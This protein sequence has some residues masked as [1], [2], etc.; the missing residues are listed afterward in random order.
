MTSDLKLLMGLDEAGRGPVL[1][2]MVIAGVVFAESSNDFFKDYGIKDSK[3][4]SLKAREEMFR[5]ID[6]EA[7]W[8]K[9]AV[10]WPEVIDRFVAL[11]GLNHL[12]CD[13]MADIISSLE[14]EKYVYVD[15][16]LSPD[17]FNG[18]LTTRLNK[19]NDI[20]CSFK[21]DTIYPVVSAASILAKVTRD[22]IIEELKSEYGDFGSGYPGDEKTQRF[23]A[24]MKE[25]TYFVRQSWKINKNAQG[26]LF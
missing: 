25:P 5:L 23:L 13:V 26:S 9:V 8:Y 22:R 16:P 2:P 19:K 17:V 15:S 21:A 7:I 10:V 18:M 4:L 20:N 11:K 24:N 14:E 6:E 3:Q 12:E 1:G